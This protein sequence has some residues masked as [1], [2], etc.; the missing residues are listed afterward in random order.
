MKWVNRIRKAIW[1]GIVAEGGVLSTMGIDYDNPQWWLATVLIPLF[2][3]FVAYWTPNQP[4]TL[5][6]PATVPRVEAS[7]GE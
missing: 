2:S 4:G 3:T 1:A 5:T 6:K 7:N